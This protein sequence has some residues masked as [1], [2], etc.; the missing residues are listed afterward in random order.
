MTVLRLL[1]ALLSCNA[2]AHAAELQSLTD[3]PI[4]L[5][6]GNIDLTLHGTY[7]NWGNGLFG[8]TPG[9]IDGETVAIGA[10]FGATDQ[11]QL[12]LGVALPIHPGA[13]FG[14][15]L[16]NALFTVD[17]RIAV[18]LDA[19]YER[20]GINGGT[21]IRND[22]ANGY[23]GGLG[24]A[25]KVPITEAVSFVTGQNGAVGFGHFNNIG[26]G[27]AGLYFGATGL[28]P[29]SSDF[30]IVSGNDS[31]GSDANI[32]INL[33]AGLLV[34][35]DPRVAVTLQAGYSAVIRTSGLT[36]TLH[37]VPLALEAVV[38]PAP[39]LDV[40]ARFSLEGYVGAS[41]ERLR[42]GASYFDLRALMIWFRFRA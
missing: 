7:T 41:D 3:R 28:T 18:R 34:Q 10:D 6:Q 2:A 33:P 35:P 16:A 11:V 38:S 1:A 23:F 21:D 17:P 36:G 14:S 24:A 42:L 32:G 13:A 22:H 12:G 29:A 4:T 25:I 40:G 20:V 31:G 9:S 15:L 8:L 37:F 26:L 27:T 5:P 19:G 39:A 30:L